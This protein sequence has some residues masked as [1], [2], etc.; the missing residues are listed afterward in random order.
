MVLAE[1]RVQIEGI[2]ETTAD[3]NSH[4][5]QIIVRCSSTVQITVCHA[6]AGAHNTCLSKHTARKALLARRRD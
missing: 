5:L 2:G 1:Q 4:W 3:S 6:N